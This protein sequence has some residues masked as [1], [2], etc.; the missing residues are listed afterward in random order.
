M[1]EQ[2]N[3]GITALPEA[4]YCRG[5]A[6]AEWRLNAEE[7]A[8]K[9]NAFVN[10]GSLL[11]V[12]LATVHTD[13]NCSQRC[14]DKQLTVRVRLEFLTMTMISLGNIVNLF[15][16]SFKRSFRNFRGKNV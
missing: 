6:R 5:S 1:S 11:S 15:D 13:V 8:L 12:L 9:S 2:N 14:S 10:A 3:T 16:F 4:H 7:T